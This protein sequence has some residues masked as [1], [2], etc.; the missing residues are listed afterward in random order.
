MRVLLGPN[1]SLYPLVLAAL[2]VS[3]TAVTETP[4]VDAARYQHRF[5]TDGMW[6][7]VL[8]VARSNEHDC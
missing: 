7:T 8:C 4:F 3:L 6:A 1:R 2:V 5:D